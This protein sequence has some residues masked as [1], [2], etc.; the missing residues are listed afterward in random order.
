MSQASSKKLIVIGGGAAGFFC[1]VNAA[2]LNPGLQVTLVEKS[3][4]LLSKVKVSGGGRCNVTHACFDI[5]DMSKRYPRGGNFVKKAFHQFFTT[6]T[7]QW[8]EERG[9]KLKA[10]KDGR[11]FPITDSSQTIIDCLLKE[12]DKYGVRIELKKEVTQIGSASG[13]FTIHFK[14]AL[15]INADYLCIACGG[16]PKSS[17]FS[18]ITASGHTIEEPVPSLFTFNMPGHPVTKLMGVSVESA[19]VRIVGTKLE[20]QGPLL[21]T[22]WGLSGPVIL[23]LSAWGARDLAA[24][25]WNFRI[26]VNWL[27]EYNEQQ[28][29]E[30]L[31]ILRFEKAGQFIENKNS[32]G[33]PQ[34]LWEFLLE[35]SG[36]KNGI[37]WADLPGTLQN[38]LV[39][40]VC[41]CELDIK[42]KTTFKEEFVTAGGIRLNEI[43][44]NT[45]MSKKLPGLYFAGEIMDVDGITGGF[46]FQHAWT[47]G[48]IAAKA[49]Y[50]TLRSFPEL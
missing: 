12:A 14:D 39:K 43:D 50:G 45:M 48:Y 6:D 25:Q 10:E 40:N 44:A 29:A 42:G 7:I 2:R 37:R 17:Q 41:S 9:V 38:K 1:A 3:N 15:S 26:M 11:M 32:F 47:S 31:K 20:E 4:K 24:L 18:W 19:R 16:F 35:Y 30:Q 36:I 22:H 21:I 28:F 33:L 23:K 27:P 49:I 34:R 13:S 8:F 5:A 46:N